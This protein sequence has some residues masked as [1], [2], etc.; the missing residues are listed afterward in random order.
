MEGRFTF[1]APALAAV[2]R[3]VRVT[4]LA[5]LTATPAMALDLEGA[6]HQV[7]DANPTLVARREMVEAARYRVSPAGAWDSPVVEV[8]AVNVPTNGHF[9]TDP[10]TM[11]M[12]GITQRVPV[13]GR[14]RL[15]RHAAG[16][17]VTAEGAAAEMAG[18]ELLGMAWEAY[19]DAYFA[20]DLV[21]RADGHR[22]E[23]ER[24]VE[25]ARARYTAGNGRLE[26]VLRAQAERAQA[27]A[28]LAA[29]QA[30]A[31]GARATLDV[32]RGLK[33]GASPDTLAPP[34]APPVPADPAAWLT[35]ITPSHPRLREM[36]ARADRY[37]FA[38]RA[39]R[40]SAWPDLELRGS[41][42][43]RETLADGTRQDNM[44]SATAGFTLPLFAG[45]RERSEGAEMDAMARAGDAERRAAELELAQQVAVTHAD[46]AAAQRTV[47]LLAD[48]VV[49]TQRRALD[50]SW[51][52]Y[53]AGSTD[54]WRVFESN[55]ALYDEETAL[56]RARQRLSRAQA[57]LLAL[58]ARGDLVGVRLPD[59]NRSTP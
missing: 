18:Y 38:A 15:S 42:G 9:D 3:L 13:F 2:T 28:D 16:E 10:M 23:M 33:P 27:L 30:E 55:H 7:W 36:S 51:A 17:G 40:R 24:L 37:R 25:S 52:A 8:G 53:Q 19:A 14:N 32:L 41:Y 43:R 54:L 5:A 26:D 39:A 4:A 45:Q 35:A 50:A 57:R 6:L 12:I 21:G 11:K 20:G 56:V 59:M 1:V 49:T 31:R 46:A 58:T 44:L 22:G 29:Y 34:P 47:R 48:T